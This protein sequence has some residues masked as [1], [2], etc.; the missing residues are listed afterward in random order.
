MESL[1]QLVQ[2]AQFSRGLLDRLF[3]SG[4]GRIFTVLQIGPVSELFF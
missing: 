4:Q 2:W 1:V 3:A